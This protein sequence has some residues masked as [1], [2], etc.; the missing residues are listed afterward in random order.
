MTSN[1]MGDTEVVVVH[2][3][4]SPHTLPIEVPTRKKR[5]TVSWM[6]RLLPHVILTHAQD[7]GAFRPVDTI[8]D[9]GRYNTQPGNRHRHRSSTVDAHDFNSTSSSL[10]GPPPKRQKTAHS[11]P[12]QP[13]S[14]TAR[15]RSPLG[16]AFSP[17]S[18]IKFH[19]KLEGQKVRLGTASEFRSVNSM[20]DS[21]PKQDNGSNRAVPSRE[22][23]TIRSRSSSGESSK[24]SLRIMMSQPTTLPKD[25]G[26]EVGGRRLNTTPT[27]T[28]HPD[29]TRLTS[30]VHAASI[31]VAA[32]DEARQ[33]TKRQPMGQ[34]RVVSSDE[35]PLRHTFRRDSKSA[36]SSPARKKTFIDS[37][38]AVT[39]PLPDVMKTK[40]TSRSGGSSRTPRLKNHDSSAGR[41]HPA[42]IPTTNFQSSSARR[43]A[44]SQV[45]APGQC[46]PKLDYFADGRKRIEYV[47][48]EY[49]LV[50]G[51]D[52]ENKIIYV[53]RDDTEV[54]NIKPR[55][56][57][58]IHYDNQDQHRYIKL[59]LR[60]TGEAFP[61]VLLQFSG[62]A[63]L[64]DFIDTMEGLGPGMPKAHSKPTYVHY[65]GGA[66]S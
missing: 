33:R 23:L 55:E 64:V 15:P 57:T 40:A 11:S 6:W 9:L 7:L 14:R 29:H 58:M 16:D 62:R 43:V 41:H 63:G 8:N 24:S 59:M 44:K 46:D 49:K 35:I 48:Q 1:R 39:P 31:S 51:V 22:F 26:R 30:K 10:K 52:V 34:A 5:R 2:H 17:K 54:L 42:D 32:S 56:I 36:E 65:S 12:I 38:S 53:R 13:S 60:E 50:V 3:T 21:R 28:Q 61:F 47:S 20:M 25:P 45:E 66:S 18:D 4:R 27:S 19:D 37:L